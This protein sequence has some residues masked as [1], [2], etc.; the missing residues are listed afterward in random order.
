MQQ[1]RIYRKIEFV[2]DWDILDYCLTTSSSIVFL[3]SVQ[4]CVCVL[5]DQLREQHPADLHQAPG[6][7]GVQAGHDGDDR[8]VQA[9]DDG[10]DGNGNSHGKADPGIDVD[11][12]LS[13]LHRTMAG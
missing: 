10:G 1:K 6:V 12:T 13:F 3:P 11:A 7:A 5:R 4:V 2:L 8:N 9:G